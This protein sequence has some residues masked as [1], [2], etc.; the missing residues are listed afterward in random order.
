MKKD[1]VNKSSSP[2]FNMFQQ[3]ETLLKKFLRRFMSNKHDIEDICQETILRAL[4]AEKTKE[5]KEP[6]AF[7]FG[8]SKNIVRK[9]LDKQS[10]SLIDFIEDFTPQEYLSS[11]TPTLED[12]ASDQQRMVFFTEA[13]A[14]LP[15]QCQRVFMMKKAYGYSHKEIAAQLGISTSTVEKHVAAGLKRCSEYMHKKTNFNEC[16]ATSI[17]IEEK[18]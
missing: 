7:L 9:Q 8:V 17:T 13:V 2:I 16:A 3:N 15:K 6:R 14:T 4:E 1:P 11:D 12:N 5:I 18:L 10:K